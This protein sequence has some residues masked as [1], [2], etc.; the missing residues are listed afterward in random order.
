MTT[1]LAVA[2]LAVIIAAIAT[3]CSTAA[4]RSHHARQPVGHVSPEAA[5]IARQARRDAHR[6]IV[7]ASTEQRLAGL[8]RGVRAA[9][10]RDRTA[11]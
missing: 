1:V 3:A 7:V 2:M 8:E 4:K 9:L 6:T 10:E 5:A 11:P